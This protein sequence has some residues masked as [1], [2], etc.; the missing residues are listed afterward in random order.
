MEGGPAHQSKRLLMIH[1]ME[2]SCGRW[3]RLLDR[4][5]WLQQQY[6]A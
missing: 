2:L 5:Q 6:L 4:L 3:Q 1:R